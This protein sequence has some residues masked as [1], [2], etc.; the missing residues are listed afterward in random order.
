[1]S[2]RLLWRVRVRLRCRR[3]GLLQVLFLAMAEDHVGQE[4]DK[5]GSLLRG[6]GRGLGGGQGEFGI[7]GSD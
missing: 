5:L 3:A 6:E 2:W 1:M 7:G 4:R